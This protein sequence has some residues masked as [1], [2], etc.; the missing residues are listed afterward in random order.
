MDMLKIMQQAREMQGRLQQAQE[1]LERI[2]VT[3][4]SGGGLVRVEM[5]GKGAVRRVA[6]DPVVVDKSDVEMLEDLV[7]AAVNEARKKAQDATS[8]E[9]AKVTGGMN[10]PFPLPF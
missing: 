7:A 5:D 3:G 1:E 6:I 2:T 8:Q 4:T 9:M 10:L